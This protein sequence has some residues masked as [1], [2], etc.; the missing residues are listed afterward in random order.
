MWAL[1][2]RLYPSTRPTQTFHEFM[3]GVLLAELGRPWI[4]QQRREAQRH[5]LVSCID[6]YA[7]VTS[8]HATEE[9]R[10]PDGRWA[11]AP[12]GP[13]QYLLALA[14]D[15]CSLVH[16]R[17]L[18]N[19]L[20]DRLRHPRQFQ[21]A[22]YEI[23][24]AA[25]FARLGYNIEW[26]EERVPRGSVHCEFFAIHPTTRASIAVEAKSRH[27]AGVL[28][29]PGTPVEANLLRGDVGRLIRD[30]ETQAPGDRPFLIFVD[31][32]APVSQDRTVIDATWRPQIMDDLRG[33]YTARGA[34]TP[35]TAIYVTN[36]SYHY[37]VGRISGRNEALQ[38]TSG[39]PAHPIADRTVF[40]DVERAVRHYG[41]VPDLEVENGG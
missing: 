16:T 14:F 35:F 19:G 1:G 22:R 2:N 10:D 30:A 32:N 36:F 15:V 13:T 29:E 25:I 31:L 26:Q 5:Y 37:D 38:I 18:P 27:R 8:R 21:G 40:S 17:S 9:N 24:V 41:E 33:R 4:E 7:A 39:A 12:D 34:T 3:V 11:V 23:A 6:A 20:M 28:H